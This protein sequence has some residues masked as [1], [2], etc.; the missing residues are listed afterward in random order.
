MPIRDGANLGSIAVGRNGLLAAAW[1]D[2]RFSSGARDGIAFARSTDGGL[3]WS[4]PIGINAVPGVQAILPSVAIRGD[5]TIGVTYYDFRNHVPGALSLATDY[6]LMAS[7]DGSSW[8]EQHVTGPF[9]FTA[10]PFAEG[11][12]V[13]DYQ[14]LSF[15][16]GTFLPFYAATNG[17]ISN[18]R[19]DIFATLLTTQ[20]V[21]PSAALRLQ[22]RHAPLPTMTPD[23]ERILTGSARATL[24]RR[25]PDRAPQRVPAP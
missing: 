6:W 23:F 19:T 22:A 8:I 7:V 17:F 3:T 2:A 5:G 20:P 18:D 12:F 21:I 15:S 1:Q 10:A 11:L 14:A 16:G 9:D 13:G 4:A 25:R 24:Q